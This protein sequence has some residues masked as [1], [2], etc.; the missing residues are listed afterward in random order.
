MIKITEKNG[1][2]FLEDETT[3]YLKFTKNYTEILVEILDN[4]LIFNEHQ[5]KEL[6]KGTALKTYDFFCRIDEFDEKNIKFLQSLG[7]EFYGVEQ[8]PE[9]EEVEEIYHFKYKEEFLINENELKDIL[10]KLDLE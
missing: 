3:K 7:F 1:L 8:N 9:K 2:Y 6:V 5:F 10:E 4:T